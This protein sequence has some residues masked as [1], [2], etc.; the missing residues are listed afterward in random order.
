MRFRDIVATPALTP[1]Q[2]AFLVVMMSLLFINPL[3]VFNL[4]SGVVL[5]FFDVIPWRQ[6]GIFIP[7]ITGGY[8]GAVS[9]A[10]SFEGERKLIP[11]AMVSTLIVGVMVA[12]ANTYAI[13]KLLFGRDMHWH[14]T[15]KHKGA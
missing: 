13:L 12:F 5:G 11:K 6:V 10:L 8:L 7:I 2:K 1:F 9:Y 3:I 4:V 15:T 14:V